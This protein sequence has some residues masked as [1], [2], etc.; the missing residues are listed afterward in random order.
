[1][2]GSLARRSAEWA[3][4]FLVV[5]SGRSG[6]DECRRMMVRGRAVLSMSFLV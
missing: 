6:L 5:D 2:V 1:M 3:N 4:G